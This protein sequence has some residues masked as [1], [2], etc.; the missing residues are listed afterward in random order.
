MIK[1]MLA[2]YLNEL[3]ISM[4]ELNYVDFMEQYQLHDEELVLDCINHYGRDQW[5]LP[6]IIVFPRWNRPKKAIPLVN[7]RIS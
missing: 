7:S 2:D 5:K 3:D 1:Q 4:N 6:F